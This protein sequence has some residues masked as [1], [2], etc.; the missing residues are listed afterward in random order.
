M[1]SPTR[2]LA[3]E[4]PHEQI[5]EFCRKWGIRKLSFFGSVVRDDFTDASDVDVL[6]EFFEERTPGWEFYA[7]IPDDF[8]SIVGGERKIDMFTSAELSPTIKSLVLAE[9][10]EAYGGG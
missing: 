6:V 8:A 2:T 3:I 5:A 9:A 4:V 7:D 10:I 1:S